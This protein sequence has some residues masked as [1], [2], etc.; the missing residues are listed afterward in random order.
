[1]SWQVALQA[2]L[3]QDLSVF[4]GLLRAQHIGHRVSEASGEQLLWVA[5]EN[6]AQQVR[7]LYQHYL[8]MPAE[9]LE[10]IAQR[11]EQQPV[12]G[13]INWQQQLLAF[14]LT[15]VI[16]LLTLLVAI[17]TRVG[18]A[19]ENVVLLTFN[20]AFIE[21]NRLWFVP[22]NETL[23]EGQWW[24]LITPIFIHF[25]WL[26]LAMNSMWFWELGRRI[27]RHQGSLFFLGFVLLSALASN[28]SQFVFS[29]PALFG[30]L[31]GVLYAL[32]GFCWIYQLLCPVAAYALPKG[33]VGMM[34]V[35]LLVCL[36]GIVSALGF[37]EIANAAHV[38]GLVV[39]C[40]VGGLIGLFARMKRNA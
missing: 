18:D 6:T 9:S 7:E 35:W 40:L 10:F 5:D 20:A 28:V 1:M 32:L 17:W 37:G 22:V 26:H 11:H 39:G 16:L 33:V 19:I 14:P 34:L 21:G 15:A 30:G 38:S 24:R 8:Q 23:A 13:K 31:S 29:G 2:P 12:A 3:E 36:F 4:C 27:E 25:G